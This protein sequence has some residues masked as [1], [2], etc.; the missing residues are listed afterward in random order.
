MKL[1][2]MSDLHFE[3]TS[4]VSSVVDP[5]ER[6]QLVIDE[7]NTLHTDAAYCVISG[8]LVDS[9][10]PD[11][12]PPLKTILEQIRIPLL[13][14]VGNHDNRDALAT[15]FETPLF[16]T[17]SDTDSGF[18]QYVVD[19]PDGRLI[20]LDTQTAGEG[21]GT[22]SDERYAW[23]EKVLVDA[24]DTPC[25]IFMH[26]PPAKLGL[27]VLD[28]ICLADHEKFIAFLG[29]FQNVKHLFAGH[30]HRPISA[31]ISGIPLTIMPSTRVLAP[32]PYPAW[33]WSE[34]EPTSEAP[35]YGIVHIEDGNAI[36]QYKQ[37][38]V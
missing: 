15:V 35:M 7:I 23:L 24:G 28:E 2:W 11:H 30:V 16:E 25:Y 3:P 5:A 31:S 18:V 32:L 22:L 14:L 38:S 1:I 27:G 29:G 6:I 10:D 33:D 9:G 8:D 4:T 12:Y 36:V 34:F 19:T 20:F 37:F 26:H 13:P 17:N 21:H